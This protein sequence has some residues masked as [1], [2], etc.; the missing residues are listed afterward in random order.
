MNVFYF[1]YALMWQLLLPHRR[2]LQMTASTIPTVIPRFAGYI[3]FL[4]PQAAFQPVDRGI[5]L[6]TAMVIHG[7]KLCSNCRVHSWL[8]ML[9]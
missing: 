7:T 8:P 2:C 9:V 4:V 6:C 5:E 3:G 1:G